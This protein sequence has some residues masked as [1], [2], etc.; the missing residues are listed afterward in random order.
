M[1]KQSGKIEI[2]SLNGTTVKLSFKH[3]ISN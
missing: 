1:E 2:S 3:A